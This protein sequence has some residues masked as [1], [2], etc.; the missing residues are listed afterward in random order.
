[1]KKHKIT[2]R[3]FALAMCLCM[4]FTM[5]PMSAHATETEHT[6]SWSDAWST[7][8]LDHWHECTAEGCNLPTGEADSGKG[9]YGTHSYDGNYTCTVCGHTC[10]HTYAG[11]NSDD[12]NH[13]QEC[14]NSCGFTTASESHD[15]NGE[16][17]I[18]SVCYY[19][20]N[21]STD[22]DEHTH[23]WGDWIS[24]GDGTHT[25]T[26][27]IDQTHTETENCAVYTV[28][29]IEG[30]GQ[31]H[32]ILCECM[33]VLGTE[34]HTMGE[35]F[36]DGEV[37]RRECTAACDYLEE[38]SIEHTH[39]WGP[40]ISDGNGSHTRICTTD[41]T[42]IQK[43]SCGEGLISDGKCDDCGYELQHTHNYTAVVTA[44]TC[45]DR[46]YT[47]YTCSCNDS[48]VGDYVD[49]LGHDWGDYVSNGN[50]THT[51]TCTTN[52]SH[53]Q[54]E[55]CKGGTATCKDLATCSY[56]SA[57]YGKLNSTN[58]S[59]G[60]EVRNAKAATETENGYT[61]DTYCLGCGIK[62]SEGDTIPATGSGDD[63][64]DTHTHNYSY[65]KYDGT[66][67]WKM[68]HCGQGQAGSVKAHTLLLHSNNNGHWKECTICNY[69]SD[70]QSHVYSDD[71]DASCNDCGYERHVHNNF[72]PATC[73]S[74][75]KCSCQTI[76]G[77]KDPS[78]HVGGTEIR[79]AVEATY[80][81]E[82]Y[83][84]DTYCKGCGVK[85]ES[86]KGIPMK[87]Y[88]I[89]KIDDDVVVED[90][91]FTPGEGLVLPEDAVLVVDPHTP[92]ED[93]LDFVLLP[94][95]A[96]PQ[97][98]VL[99]CSEDTMKDIIKST[100][101]TIIG[102]DGGRYTQHE[103]LLI[104]GNEYYVSGSGDGESLL[105]YDKTG[106]M[107]SYD[108]EKEPQVIGQNAGTEYPENKFISINDAIYQI[109]SVLRD[110]NGNETLIL[111]LDGKPAGMIQSNQY[112]E[113]DSINI[114][115]DDYHP[116]KVKERQQISN[117]LGTVTTGENPIDGLE[118]GK[119]YN[120]SVIGSNDISVPGAENVNGTITQTFAVPEILVGNENVVYAA[121]HKTTT[122]NET[123]T[124]TLSEDG[125]TLTATY[126]VSSFSPFIVYAFVEADE[127][128]IKTL[129]AT[130]VDGS[131]DTT[132][133][134][135]TS[136]PV[137]SPQ[138][139]DNT[140]WYILIAVVAGV[141]AV[142]SVV[143]GKRR[144]SKAN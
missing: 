103:K 72:Y 79:N 18:C 71:S 102:P 54:T 5:M 66:N 13:W 52:N 88:V 43:E 104:N 115:N 107:Y 126:T 120:V 87:G 86:G 32:N 124:V 128:E 109:H 132:E 89:V 82:G 58:H 61:G 45:S 29:M 70:L 2:K 81:T 84:G 140:V 67:H 90:V 20:S 112:G 76:I 39:E 42:H 97:T 60:T 142:A 49:S 143:Y 74:P 75:A 33:Y 59:G 106:N 114:Y 137:E 130:I 10:S 85:L 138:T 44:P 56:C 22:P 53:Y 95:T 131:D 92:S 105:L 113:M 6:H 21:S 65:Y 9:G 111:Y 30:D 94:E 62:I 3:F 23:D 40:Y 141:I 100:D 55:G 78:N 108:G 27:T 69:Y 46:G 135:D 77:D 98:R 134:P 12:S 34:A 8:T 125:K 1:M 17:G 91:T 38:R 16:N 11:Y 37:E 15:Q 123:G 7:N 129:S 101:A 14:A 117:Y 96:K 119:T 28:A 121:V 31:N 116:A 25:H 36:L 118:S 47:T 133:A 48:Y 68:C 122:G 63:D 4:I 35:W 127:P 80:E 24:N 26:C 41:S 93:D 73:T 136:E 83:T 110:T 64:D 99:V 19:D 144:K 57:S 139:S 51:Q 50:G